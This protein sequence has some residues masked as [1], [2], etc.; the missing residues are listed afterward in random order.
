MLTIANALIE[1]LTFSIEKELDVLR[2]AMW[3]RRLQSWHQLVLTVSA[4][5]MAQSEICG[6]DKLWCHT[7]NTRPSHG[8]NSP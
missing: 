5:S 3:L 7:I 4:H 1:L 8:L 2:S 6:A